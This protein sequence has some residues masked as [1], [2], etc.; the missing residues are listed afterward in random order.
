MNRNSQHS[1][2]RIYTELWCTEVKRTLV[3]MLTSAPFLSKID[4]I[5]VN[6]DS[7]AAIK[8]V[9]PLCREMI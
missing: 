7:V 8:G 9:I 2:Q 5:G 1:C 4:T 3:S 6:P